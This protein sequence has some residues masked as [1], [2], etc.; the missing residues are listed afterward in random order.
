MNL[1][2][3]L[4]ILVLTT[5][6]L[7]GCS[8]TPDV[9][10]PAATPDIEATLEARLA[11]VPTPTARVIEVEVEKIVVATATPTPP[12]PTPTPTPPIPTPTPT[13]PIP[14]PTPTPTP[15]AT[16]T[17]QAT[18]APAATP[19]PMPMPT[20]TNTADLKLSD[21]SSD[22][23]TII[24]L[25]L[26]DPVLTQRL[27]HPSVQGWG[28]ECSGVYLSNISDKTVTARR[29]L[30][31]GYAQND[32][33]VETF[34]LGHNYSL[35]PGH[36]YYRELCFQ[37]RVTRKVIEYGEIY[38]SAWSYTG[39]FPN[40]TPL[41]SPFSPD[42]DV[43]GPSMVTDGVLRLDL[44]GAL[45]GYLEETS[46]FNIPLILDETGAF[47][48]DVSTVCQRHAV[49]AGSLGGGT[50]SWPGRL[51]L[52]EFDNISDIDLDV[53][54]CWAWYWLPPVEPDT[55][56]DWGCEETNLDAKRNTAVR[57][58][59]IDKYA[60]TP[61]VGPWRLLG[62]WLNTREKSPCRTPN[63]CNFP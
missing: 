26:T 2:T 28:P 11:A 18:A 58:E 43:F 3:L 16:P 19:T 52:G 24:D 56:R 20:P 36:K 45:G 33:E 42:I 55:L 38:E 50:C 51:L 15:T 63:S 60:D 27:G 1:R 8:T 7:L 17:P 40:L 21:L 6:V 13:P 31:T 37:E 5:F 30:I 49:W 59:A 47:I 14:T 62:L 35:L 53:I 48:E 32:V 41:P 10:A 4:P 12:I 54:T 44:A 23:T 39:Y 46:G 61:E 57:L 22:P 29:I 9:P 34:Q 25:R